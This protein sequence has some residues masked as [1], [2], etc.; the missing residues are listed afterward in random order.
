MRFVPFFRHSTSTNPFILRPPDVAPPSRST[1]LQAQKKKVKDTSQKKKRDKGKGE[2]GQ[3]RRL[4]L[5]LHSPSP[6]LFFLKNAIACHTQAGV[7][8]FPHIT[9]KISPAIGSFF[10]VKSIRPFD[11]KKKKKKKKK[12][13][14]KSKSKI[15]FSSRP[16]TPSSFFS[17]SHPLLLQLLC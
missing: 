9:L 7:F 1:S 3:T 8:F 10:L 14:S 4:L 6:S 11:Q 13:K 2:K 16:F 5:F 15:I 17:L 12:S